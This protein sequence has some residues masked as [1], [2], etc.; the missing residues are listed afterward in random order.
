MSVLFSTPKAFAEATATQMLRSSVPSAVAIGIREINTTSSLEPENGTILNELKTSFDLDINTAL[1]GDKA[2][3]FYFY[4]RVKTF[5]G[6]ASAFGP[7]GVI[8]F[9]NTT[10]LPTASA[11]ANARNGINGNVDVIGYNV[12]MLP[13][14]AN[15]MNV[16]FLTA[17]EYEDAYK[18]NF[19][20][21]AISG[22][23]NQII[24]GNALRTTFN[25]TEDSAGTYSVTV[26]V[27]A[28]ESL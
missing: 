4:A 26:C 16:Q 2:Y 15:K 20:N 5:D 6:E 1:S 27:T 28:L 11:V 23:I 18:V 7:N 17:T 21:D 13:D 25:S 19:K 10:S 9:G 24:A 12:K 3:D 14:D 22:T 8:L